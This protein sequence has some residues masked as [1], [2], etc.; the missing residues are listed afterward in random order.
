MNRNLIIGSLAAL[1]L[2]WLF[3]RDSGSKSSRLAVSTPAD[4]IGDS[5]AVGLYNPLRKELAVKGVQLRGHGKGGSSAPQWLYNGWLDQVLYLQP[6]MVL[7]SLGTNDSAPAST[8]G[9]KNF[10]PAIKKIVEAIRAAG[11]QPVLLAPPPMPWSLNE[12]NAG[13][14]ATG[15]PVIAAPV[16]LQRQPDKIHLTP[17]GNVQWAKAIAARFS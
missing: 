12:I 17:E 16:N 14:Q 2:V 3:T 10:P 1:G 15:A 6:K 4:L 7:V 11:A 13:L 9:K 8:N 5:L